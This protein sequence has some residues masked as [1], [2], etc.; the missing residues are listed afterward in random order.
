MLSLSRDDTLGEGFPKLWDVRQN[1][2]QREPFKLKT[3]GEETTP[4]LAMKQTHNSQSDRNSIIE[5]SISK[6]NI[7]LNGM[8]WTAAQSMKQDEMIDTPIH[9]AV[10]RGDNI[11]QGMTACE[12]GPSK[13]LQYG[14]VTLLQ[15]KEECSTAE[16]QR[17]TCKFECERPLSVFVEIQ[18]TTI[19]QDQ[20][21]RSP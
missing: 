4:A 1:L 14:K 5:F 2:N 7:E 13:P 12:S 16:Q 17:L 20:Q 19:C 6:A 8:V 18:L 21:L 10:Y 9:L 11:V 3:A 15:A